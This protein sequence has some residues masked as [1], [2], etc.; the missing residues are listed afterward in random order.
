MAL[1]NEDKST[2]PFAGFKAEAYTDGLP[3]Q[4]GS[5]AKKSTTSVPEIGDEDEA[6]NQTDPLAAFRDQGDQDDELSDEADGGDGDGEGAGSS[7]SAEGDDND[8]DS[9]DGGEEDADEGDDEVTAKAKEIAQRMAQKRIDT[10]TKARRE[11][12]RRAAELE[13]E[14]EALRKQNSSQKDAQGQGGEQDDTTSEPEFE[15]NDPKT[16][17]ALSEPDPKNYK[18]GEVDSAYL[19]DVVNY[20]TAYAQAKVQHD[21]EQA[22]QAQAAEQHVQE[23]RESWD[24]V[25]ED[26]LSRYDD[27]EEVVLVAGDRG[28]FDLTQATF[29]MAAQSEFGADI[30]YH[31]ATN[32]KTASKV[33]QMTERD[34]A[35][36]L[37]RL[38]AALET[39][40]NSGDKGKQ[41]RKAPGAAPPPN[42]RTP[43][44]KGGKFVNP[45]RSENFADFEAAVARQNK[46]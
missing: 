1:E 24:K 7:A 13:A 22:R 16:G 26:G 12:E 10:I 11:A 33:A 9:E 30:L 41:R 23:L 40:R 44:G 28:D 35:R 45:A 8:D 17:K 37:G 42:R 20:Q 32:P 38:E 31:L 3:A 15:I 4:E 5:E 25:Q 43:R 14:M 46:R 39:S 2:D 19:R 27:F 29:E 6:A 36:Y 34:Q 18:Y 21:A